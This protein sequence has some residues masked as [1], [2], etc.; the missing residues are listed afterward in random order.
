MTPDF[1][2]TATNIIKGVELGEKAFISALTLWLL[3]I[4]LKNKSI[5]YFEK[6]LLEKI[7]NLKNLTIVSLTIKSFQNALVYQEELGLDAT[8]FPVTGQGL[9]SIYMLLF[10]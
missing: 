9:S 6:I 2:E 4:I 7:S 10:L 5:D 8:S 3:H 1:G